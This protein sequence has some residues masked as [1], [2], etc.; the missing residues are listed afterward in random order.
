MRLTYS[1]TINGINLTHRHTF[2][3]HNNGIPDIGTPFEEI[4]ALNWNGT[5]QTLQD[6]VN[7]YV[8]L[9][10]PLYHTTTEFQL[11]ELWAYPTD[12]YD[13]TYVSSYPLAENGT[14]TLAQSKP[15][16]QLTHTYRTIAGGLMK[17]VYLESTI[18]RDTRIAFGASTGAES[19][20]MS[21]VS[22][23]AQPF[24]AR[25]DYRPFAPLNAIGG[26]NEAIYRKRYRQT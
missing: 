18:Q 2:D 17:M 9:L 1:V 3:I 14:V 24:A 22:H 15:A 12:G 10:K 6:F 16:G 21:F 23:P 19:A 25:D 8:D 20:L 7:S 26:Q 5:T 13:A 4:E 11:F